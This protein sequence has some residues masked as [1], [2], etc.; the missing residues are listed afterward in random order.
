MSRRIHAVAAA[1]IA[2]GA[3]VLAGV[4]EFGLPAQAAASCSAS[5]AVPWMPL[6]G[7]AYPAEAF[8]NGPSCG[9]AA[10]TLVVRA[11]DG[12]ALWVDAAPAAQLMTFVEVRTREQMARALSEWLSQAHSFKTSAELPAWR[13]GEPAPKSGEFAFI[14]EAGMDRASYEK[15]R[16]EKLPLFCY[17]QGMESLSCI[18]LKD[19][20]MTKVG[21]QT[22]PG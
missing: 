2:A 7:R 8:S 6:K 13:N 3:S 12:T 9:L 15:T 11:P 22:F 20:Q 1:A 14:P 16:A 5:A 19:G 21:V 17:V 10:V 18:A 4:E